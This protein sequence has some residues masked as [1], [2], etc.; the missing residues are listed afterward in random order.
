MRRFACHQYPDPMG[1]R[2][3][4]A[5]EFSPTRMVRRT[6][7]KIPFTAELATLGRS[8]TRGARTTL[9]GTGRHCPIDVSRLVAGP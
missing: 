6:L 7:V 9:Y 4:D 1:R 5:H 2:K 3:N 8:G